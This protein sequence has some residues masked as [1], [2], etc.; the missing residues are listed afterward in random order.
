MK[1]NRRSDFTKDLFRLPSDRTITTFAILV[2][3][4]IP[5]D[6]AE[7]VFAPVGMTATLDSLYVN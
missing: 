5:Q 7:T 1:K 4:D 2:Q 6:F 3:A